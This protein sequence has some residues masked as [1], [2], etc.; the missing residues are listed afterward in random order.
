[1]FMKKLTE[2][3]WMYGLSLITGI[4]ILAV[5]SMAASGCASTPK[6]KMEKR[7][8]RAEIKKMA[9]ETLKMLYKEQPN[10]KRLIA[11]SAGY[12]VFSNFGTKIMFVGGGSGQG[13]AINN[14]TK[15]GV[16]MKMV[17]AQ[18]GIGMGIKKFRQVWVFTQNRDLND[19]IN[20][21]WETSGQ[22][23]AAAKMDDS[24]DD[25]AMAVSV[26]PGV[27]LYQ[28]TDSGL[29]LELTA[30]GTKYYKNDALN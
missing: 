14:K 25:Y 12:A 22:G 20:S 13:I 10:A 27:W 29:A 5:L 16:Y 6:T 1:M 30:K 18:V 11:K 4:G 9:D 26:S 7:K 2:M 23:T 21:G 19:F 28:L 8:A 17:E 24:G 15:K 3:S